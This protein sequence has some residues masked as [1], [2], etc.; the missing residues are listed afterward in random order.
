MI[1]GHRQHAVFH[2]L[3]IIGLNGDLDH[4]HIR[5]IALQARH[6]GQFSN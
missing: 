3:R 5:L 6:I 1:E 4:H 2:R